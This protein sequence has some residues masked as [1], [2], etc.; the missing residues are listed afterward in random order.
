MKAYIVASGAY[1][2]NVT[3]ELPPLKQA[4]NDS[5][6][7]SVRRVG[8][9][10]Q[11][12]L[13]GAGRAATGLPA[14]SAVYLTSGRGDIGSTVETLDAIYRLEQAPRPVSFINSVSNAACFYI[15]QSL[16]LRGPGL[17]VRESDGA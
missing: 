6:G 11:L 13:I 14:Q 17:F 1:C 5:V 10:I 16:G 3:S 15:A 8:R 4:V 9:F 2:E 7:H 12:A